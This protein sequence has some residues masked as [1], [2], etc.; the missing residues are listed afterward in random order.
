MLRQSL[1]KTRLTEARILLERASALGD[2]GAEAMLAGYSARGRFGWRYV[3]HGFWQLG[4]ASW[5][6]VILDDEIILASRS[7]APALMTGHE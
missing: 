6:L 4:I 5:K 1:S 3:P 2:L 7:E